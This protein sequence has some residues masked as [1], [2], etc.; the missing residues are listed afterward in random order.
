MATKSGAGSLAAIVFFLGGLFAAV[1][2]SADDADLIAALQSGGHIAL[3]RHSTAP[4]SG[5]PPNFR[6]GDCSTQ[7]N[8]SEAGRAQAVDIGESLRANGLAETRVVS[9]QWC[10]CLDTAELLSVGAVEELPFLNSLVSYPAERREMTQSLSSWIGEQ[11]LS[12]ATLLV[13]H[14]VN[15]GAL[16]GRAPQEGEIII[17]ER[18]GDGEL[19]VVG[20]I[21][22][23]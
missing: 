21:P 14:S 2:A 15:I 8:L 7:R 4:G 16:V 3:M 13:T 19:I 10:R 5:D 18:A 22:P 9:S 12:G 20:S 11:D 6:I 17:V 23:P 1:G